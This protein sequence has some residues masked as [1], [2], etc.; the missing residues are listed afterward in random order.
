MI[1]NCE[2][3]NSNTGCMSNEASPWDDV[4]QTPIKYSYFSS[5]SI[6]IS[7]FQGGMDLLSHRFIVIVKSYGPCD[8]GD[9]G[10]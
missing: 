1:E 3:F 9:E 5:C 2:K 6:P 8:L 4:I 10:I 7:Y